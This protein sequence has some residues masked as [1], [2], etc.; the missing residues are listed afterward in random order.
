MFGSEG[1]LRF[2]D[3][4]LSGARRGETALRPIEIPS[5]E[6][7]GWRVEEEFIG[8]IRRKEHVQLTTFAD[9]VKYMEFTEAVARSLAERRVIPLP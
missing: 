1:T 9:G 6:R 8:A 2:H 5:H 4:Q 7:G 3:G